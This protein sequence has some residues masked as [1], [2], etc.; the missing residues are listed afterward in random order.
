MHKYFQMLFFEGKRFPMIPKEPY[1]RVL[2]YLQAL[3]TPNRI[4]IHTFSFV[5]IPRTSY[6]A[7]K[8]R[9]VSASIS[10]EF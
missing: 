4:N 3:N 5:A 1:L 8:A 7:V 6:A 2:S 10:F 9:D